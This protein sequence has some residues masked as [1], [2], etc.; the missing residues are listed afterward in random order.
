[1]LNQSQQPEPENS[2]PDPNRSTTNAQESTEERF[3]TF[4]VTDTTSLEV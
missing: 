3:T 1:M 4:S 2:E